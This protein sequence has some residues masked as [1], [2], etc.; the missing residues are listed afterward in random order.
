MSDY[1]RNPIR[2]EFG[3]T[4]NPIDTIKLQAYEVANDQK[5][6]LLQKYSL[7]ESG[8]SPGLRRAP[9]AG[10]KLAPTLDR[11]RLRS[12]HDP[13]QPQPIA[14]KRRASQFPE[15]KSKLLIATDVASRGIHVDDIAHVI[16]Y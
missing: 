16:N 2:L 8:R 1:T 6:A 15:G 11:G 9:S 4:L 14:K 3:S 7:E 5:L 13:R 10:P 12:H